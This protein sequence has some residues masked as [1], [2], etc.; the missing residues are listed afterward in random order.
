MKPVLVGG[1]IDGTSGTLT[2]PDLDFNWEWDI[3]EEITKHLIIQP[4]DN[5]ESGQYTLKVYFNI[6]VHS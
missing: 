3:N 6:C 1:F 4:I 5:G 2:A